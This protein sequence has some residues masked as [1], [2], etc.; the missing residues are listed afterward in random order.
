MRRLAAACLGLLQGACSSAGGFHSPAALTANIAEP[1][2]GDVE[3]NLLFIGDA[4]DPGTNTGAQSEPVLRALSTLAR[5]APDRTTIVYLGDNIYPDGMP[6]AQGPGRQR[7]ERILDQQIDTLL[8]RSVR[9]IFIAGN[10]DWND[11]GVMWRSGGLDRIAA[12]GEYLASR[13]EASGIPVKLAPAAGCPGPEVLDVGPR[14]RVIAIDTQWWLQRQREPAST[15]ACSGAGVPNDSASSVDSL[16]AA[17]ANAGER[18]VVVVAHHPLVSG[19]RRGGYCR[20]ALSWCGLANLWAR[21]RSSPAASRQDIAHPE[22]ARIRNVLSAALATH[23]PLIYAAGHDHDLQVIRAVPLGSPGSPGGLVRYHVVS[24]SG[25]LG[26][27]R[28]VAC[29]PE[30]LLA[31]ADAGFVRLAVLHDGRAA[32]SVITVAED[33]IPRERARFWLN[34]PAPDAA[35]C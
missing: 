14:L 21:L 30:S 35:N 22:Y 9:R 17:L 13:Q 24:G 6:V 18:L 33:G 34:S 4:G 5:M 23:P 16:R 11:A 25:S 28:A 20:Q 31:T 8:P 12:Q 27:G 15:R 2:L 19:G 10:H 29:L 26:H 1:A 7:A 32:L 3:S